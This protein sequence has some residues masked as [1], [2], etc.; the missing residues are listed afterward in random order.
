MRL[1]LQKLIHTPGESLPF[2]FT[3]D[4]SEVDV[5]GENPV[6]EPVLVSGVVKNTAG[7]LSL[8]AEASSQLSRCCD[9]CGKRFRKGQETHIHFLLSQELQ[10]EESDDI[11]LLDGDELDVSELAYTAFILGMDTKNLCSEDCKGLCSGCGANLNEGLCR[12]KAEV[13]PRWAALAQFLDK[14]E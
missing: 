11:L 7:M 14:T 3:L 4:L 13:D 2:D 1:H 9:R 6:C 10:D 5:G 12:C 8:E